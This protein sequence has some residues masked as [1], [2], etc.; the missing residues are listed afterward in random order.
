LERSGVA[1]TDTDRHLRK[2][3]RRSEEAWGDMLRED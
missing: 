1:F 3:R 2:T